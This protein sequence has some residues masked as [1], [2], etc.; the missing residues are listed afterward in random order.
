MEIGE[1]GWIVN[2]MALMVAEN[3]RLNVN[4]KGNLLHICLQRK[5]QTK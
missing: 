4:S 5:K 1:E 3:Y 2:V